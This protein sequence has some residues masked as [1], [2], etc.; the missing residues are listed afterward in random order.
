M[1]KKDIFG[2]GNVEEVK[3]DSNSL[4]KVFFICLYYYILIPFSEVK[5]YFMRFYWTKV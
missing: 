3:F 2:H 5:R 1:I 4:E